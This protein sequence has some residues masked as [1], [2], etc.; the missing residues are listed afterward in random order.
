MIDFQTF[1]FQE[2]LQLKVELEVELKKREQEE[3]AA[4]RK[5]ILEIARTFN[6]DLDE[7]FTAPKVGAGAPRRVVEPKY[8]NPKDPEQTWTGRGRSPVWVQ[9]FL[10]T[11][12]TLEDLLINKA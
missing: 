6:F 5:K 4:A 12:G 1:T 9:D 10:T 11:G 2:L 8:F 7:L 3:K